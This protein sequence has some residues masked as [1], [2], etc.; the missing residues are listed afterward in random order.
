MYEAFD[1]QRPHV[2]PYMARTTQE[3][4]EREAFTRELRAL[5]ESAVDT[6]PDGL[7]EVFVLR[8]VEGLSTAEAAACLGLTGDAVK[9]RLAR[10]RA[11]LRRVLLDRTGATAPDAFRFYRPRC[12]KVVAAASDPTLAVRQG[13]TIEWINDD[14][15]PHT[16]TS[17]GGAFDS[18]AIA[19]GGTCRWTAR[20]R[21][22]VS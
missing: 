5:L 14:I 16:A 6:L 10:G 9:T 12:D 2:V 13:D 22:T 15:V 11:A 20:A 8:D 19:A 1:D 3:N 21:G 4:P 18:G 17:T 7:R